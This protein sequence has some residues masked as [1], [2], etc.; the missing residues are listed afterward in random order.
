RFSRDWSSD[1]CSSDLTDVT[2]L[3]PTI[4]HTG[5]SVDPNTG[6]EKDFTN[7]VTYTVKATDNTTAAY[8]VTVNVADDTPKAITSFKFAGLS[9]SEER[10]VGKESRPRI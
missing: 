2:K 8:T 4:V 7:P 6:V 9:R 10:R 1:V 3:T 5:A